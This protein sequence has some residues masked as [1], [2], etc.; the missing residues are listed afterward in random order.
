MCLEDVVAGE[1]ARTLPCF[2]AFHQACVDVWLGAHETCPN[3]KAD[4]RL[5]ADDGSLV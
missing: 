3:C 1:T 2:H 5:G 4:A